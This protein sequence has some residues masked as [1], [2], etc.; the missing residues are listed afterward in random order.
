[1]FCYTHQLQKLFQQIIKQ[2]NVFVCMQL[3]N[4]IALLRIDCDQLFTI[5]IVNILLKYQNNTYMYHDQ[6]SRQ[7]KDR[8]ITGKFTYDIINQIKKR[9]QKLYNFEF[10]LIKIMISN[11]LKF[12]MKFFHQNFKQILIVSDSLTRKLFKQQAYEFIQYFI[13]NDEQFLQNLLQN[14]QF[15]QRQISR[16]L[17]VFSL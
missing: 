2:M 3:Y 9:M 15:F 6:L 17:T 14:R 5:Y 11:N 4:K 8:R 10:V 7:L 12:F 1:M 13:K 16:T